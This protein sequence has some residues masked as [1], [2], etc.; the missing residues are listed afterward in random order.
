MGTF[1]G[2]PGTGKG[3]A[4][5]GGPST[6]LSTVVLAAGANNNIAPATPYGRIDL[7]SSAGV[8]NVTGIVA[9]TDGQV[10]TLRNKPGGNAVTLNNL[11]AG[12]LAAN[13]LSGPAG[14]D[15]VLPAGTALTIVYYAGSIKLWVLNP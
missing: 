6:A 11:N 12:S 9:G 13:Q 5:G 15:V 2:P 10:A 8:A 3:A 1:F 14:N 4:G 7:D